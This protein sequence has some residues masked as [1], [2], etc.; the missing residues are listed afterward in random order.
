MD[1]DLVLQLERMYIAYAAFVCI[2]GAKEL[3]NSSP[4]GY[5][6]DILSWKIER[7]VLRWASRSI[8]SSTIGK[9]GKLA[10]W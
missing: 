10:V 6:V 7:I 9:Q 2:I 3:I 8:D 1:R 5:M 4:R